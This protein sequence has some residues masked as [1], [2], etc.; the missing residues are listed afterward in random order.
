MILEPCIY[1]IMNEALVEGIYD[2]M[3][4]GM[5]EGMNA[6]MDLKGEGLSRYE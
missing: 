2:I 1:D 5:L 4:E 6:Y 3:N